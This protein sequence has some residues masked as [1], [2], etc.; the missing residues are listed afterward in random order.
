MFKGVGPGKDGPRFAENGHAE[1][2]TETGDLI[3]VGAVR[4]KTKPDRLADKRYGARPRDVGQVRA[5]KLC[6]RRYGG[7]QNSHAGTL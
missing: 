3:K 2:I 5:F 4:V 1:D 6:D 7:F